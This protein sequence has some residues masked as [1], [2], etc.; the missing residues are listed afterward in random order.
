M[1]RLADVLLLNRLGS[2][3]IRDGARHPEDAVI[4]SGGETQFFDGAAEEPTPPIGQAGK[5]VHVGRM[6]P[7]VAVDAARAET[8]ALNLPAVRNPF[9]NHFRLLTR[10]FGGHLVIGDG[11]DLDVQVD[12]VEQR[13][14]EFADVFLNARRGTDTAAGEITM[15]PAGAFLRCL[16]AIGAFPAKN[17]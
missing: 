3:Q 11:G 16:F 12:P 4:G 2:R 5:L 14:G 17:P 8:V 10:T 13:P 9:A 1:N 6:H 15:I 7:G